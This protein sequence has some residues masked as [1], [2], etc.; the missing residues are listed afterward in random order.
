MSDLEE[1]LKHFKFPGF[2]ACQE[3]VSNGHYTD[4]AVFPQRFS[5]GDYTDHW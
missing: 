2:Q 5:N 4:H 1:F 3:I